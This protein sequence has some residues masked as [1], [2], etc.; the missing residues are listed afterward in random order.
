MV[1]LS[2]YTVSADGISAAVSITKEPYKQTQ[3]SIEIPHP[4]PATAAYMDNIKG[5]MLSQVRLTTQEV[6][7]ITMMIIRTVSRVPCTLR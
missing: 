2:K 5:E 6:L 7:D 4:L 1:V 3:Y